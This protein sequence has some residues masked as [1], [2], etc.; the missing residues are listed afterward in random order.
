[1]INSYSQ[2]P[3]RPKRFTTFTNYGIKISN[4]K[5]S[6]IDSRTKQQK[7]KLKLFIYNRLF[8]VRLCFSLKYSEDER[9]FLWLWQRRITPHSASSEFL[10]QLKT[11]LFQLID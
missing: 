1:M 6:L 8:F 4:A 3:E 9:N 10:L 2:T 5:T 7:L 11:V